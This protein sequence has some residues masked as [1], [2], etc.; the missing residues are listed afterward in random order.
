M[1]IVLHELLAK[2]HNICYSVHIYIMTIDSLDRQL[3]DLLMQDAR[4]TSEELARYLNVSSSTVRRRMKKLVDQGIV[5]IVAIP[6]PSEV[7]LFLEAVIALDVPHPK[8]VSVLEKLHSYPQ[9]RWVAGMSGRF[10]IMAYVWLRSTDELHNFI[11]EVGKIEGVT[12]TETFICLHV[13]KS[14]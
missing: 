1:S 8:V 12:K 10:D 13:E 9:I 3:I 6:E 11:L 4:R 5:H 2:Y 14:P 7:G